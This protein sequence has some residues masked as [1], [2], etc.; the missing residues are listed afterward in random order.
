[1][2]VR[3][4][5]INHQ[6]GEDDVDVSG[7]NANEQPGGADAAVAA[8]LQAREEAIDA[9]WA[10]RR[11]EAVEEAIANGL[12]PA[13][14]KDYHLAAMAAGDDPAAAIKGFRSAVAGDG[15]DAAELT[16][17]VAQRNDAASAAAPRVHFDT[18][19]GALP[20]SQP[21]LDRLAAVK[22]VQ[23]ERNCTFR[24][25]IDFYAAARREGAA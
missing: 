8:D 22:Q 16:R 13:T 2:P 15:A 23:T 19:A 6:D 3:A 4:P 9:L 25:A 24:E 5:A 17:G 21:G 20:A 7:E 11:E 1:M 10:E 18:A 14:A 12:M